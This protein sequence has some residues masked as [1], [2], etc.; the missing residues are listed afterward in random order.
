MLVKMPAN[1]SLF[2]LADLKIELEGILKKKVDLLTF[3]AL[4]PLVRDRILSETVK[5]L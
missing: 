5:V 2:D 4:H 1:S 3:K